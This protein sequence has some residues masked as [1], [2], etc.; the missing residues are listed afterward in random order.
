MSGP[1]AVIIAS[2]I[3]AWYAVTTSDGLVSDDYYKQG[4]A[5]GETLA[6]NR[7]AEE[8]G[9]AASLRLKADSVT[10]R[11]TGPKADAAM[12]ATLSVML[13]HPTRAG[14][15][16]KSVLKRTGEAYTGVLHLPASGHWLVLIEDEAKT[17]RLMGSV[18]LPAANETVIGGEVA[19]AKPKS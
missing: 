6:K 10:V 17:W 7:H 3:S 9:I 2:F 16:Q 18:V 15:D 5:A 11:L 14:L 19:A 4:M 1:F 8:L 12:P 13:S